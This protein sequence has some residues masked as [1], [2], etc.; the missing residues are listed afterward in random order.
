MNFSLLVSVNLLLLYI[1]PKG[2]VDLTK[3]IMKLTT[4][5]TPRISN[6]FSLLF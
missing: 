1:F 2:S 6:L 4:T 3:I 5:K